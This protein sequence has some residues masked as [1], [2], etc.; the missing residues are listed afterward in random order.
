MRLSRAFSL[1]GPCFRA[2]PASR[3]AH[4]AHDGLKSAE[5][6]LPGYRRTRVRSGMT[7]LILLGIALIAVKDLA[8]H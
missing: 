2:H 7:A 6:R 1:S 8:Y 3:Q 4:A 5:K